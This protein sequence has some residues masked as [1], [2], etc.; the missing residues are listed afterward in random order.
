MTEFG[1]E[2][3]SVETTLAMSGAVRRAHPWWRRNESKLVSIAA[4]TDVRGTSASTH[5]LGRSRGESRSVAT[6]TMNGRHP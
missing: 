6:R 3:K 1:K 2:S 5:E 4:A